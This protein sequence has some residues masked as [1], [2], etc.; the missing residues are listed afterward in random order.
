MKS[1]F[2]SDD[3]DDDEDDNY[4]GEVDVPIFGSK[5]YEKEEKDD[6]DDDLTVNLTPGKITRL[7]YLPPC[8][9][10][11]LSKFEAD[12][13]VIQ[14]KKR[15]SMP[16]PRY[17]KNTKDS[18]NLIFDRSDPNLDFLLVQQR[19]QRLLDKDIYAFLIY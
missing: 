17:A 10:H 13:E 2:V 18:A 19:N 11:N 15:V 5:E 12:V 9:S 6:K 4:K 8:E 7:V 14:K 3:N 16:N 1:T